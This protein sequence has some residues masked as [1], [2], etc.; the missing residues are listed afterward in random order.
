MEHF[1]KGDKVIKFDKLDLV[2]TIKT[3][4]TKTNEITLQ[5]VPYGIYD[6]NQ[7]HLFDISKDLVSGDIIEYNSVLWRVLPYYRVSE[8]HILIC[9]VNDGSELKINMYNCKFI[10]RP[11][12]RE[13]NNTITYPYKCVFDIKSQAINSS[14]I[15]EPNQKPELSTIDEKIKQAQYCYYLSSLKKETCNNAEICTLWVNEIDKLLKM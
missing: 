10:E 8:K 4:N 2:F 3:H 14:V 15:P 1:K 9:S 12:K 5:E 13:S 7:F 11:I 6:I